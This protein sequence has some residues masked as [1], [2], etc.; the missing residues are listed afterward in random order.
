MLFMIVKN[1][2]Q[3]NCP[4]EEKGQNSVYYIQVVKF[5]AVMKMNDPDLLV[6][7]QIR[8]RNTRLR[9]KNTRCRLILIV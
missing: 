5:Y 8:F 6:L 2:K 1:L 4:S 3:S 9:K 7:I